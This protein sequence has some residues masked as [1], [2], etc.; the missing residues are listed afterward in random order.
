MSIQNTEY[1]ITN[2][3]RI[4]KEM[5]EDRKI[6]ISNLNSINDQELILLHNENQIFDI[7]VNDELK[8][9]YYMANKIKI[10]NIKSFIDEEND[11]N[12]IFISKEKLTTNNYKSFSDFKEKN[13]N[14]QFFFI[15]ELLFNIYKHEYV[16]KH[17]VI[18][19]K[20]V[21]EI[22]TKYLLKNLYQLPIL[23]NN[24]PICKYLDIK[25]GSV[26]KITRPSPTAGEYILY[27][28]V[29]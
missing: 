20:E 1:L 2:S 21:E 3:F 14:F 28:Y 12:V 8:V 29:V 13:I 17:E 4:L 10:Q 11:K 5:L 16:P 26:V 22:K 25:P 6:D 23:L 18:T 27:R 9:V 24:D 19:D 7:K 15:K